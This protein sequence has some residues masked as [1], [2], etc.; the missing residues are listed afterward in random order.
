MYFPLY[1][2]TSSGNQLAPFR[3]CYSRLHELRSL[4]PSV[5]ILALTA[6]ATKSTLNTI[7]D[8]LAIENPCFLSESPD[9]QNMVYIVECMSKDSNFEQYFK[10]LADDVVKHGKVT[11]R[12]IIYCQ[13]IKQC[14]KMYN[15]LKS[16]LGNNLYIGQLW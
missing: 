11:E 3:E 15:S 4:A 7:V 14:S 12:T 8:V 16:M 6:T 5:N 1:R 2:G 9:K 13:T 10:W